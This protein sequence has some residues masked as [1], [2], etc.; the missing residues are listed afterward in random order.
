MSHTPG[1]W[2]FDGDYVESLALLKPL[3]VATLADCGHSTEGNG[4]LIAAAPELLAALHQVLD[5]LIL[6]MDWQSIT[7]LEDAVELATEAINKAEGR[8]E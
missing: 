6:R 4:I 5:V 2:S 1:P 7:G 8:V 3:S